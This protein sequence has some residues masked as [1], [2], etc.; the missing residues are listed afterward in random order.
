[1]EYQR[2]SFL[3]W[4]SGR[5]LVPV[6]RP[7]LCGVGVGNVP[8]CGGGGLC[9]AHCWVLRQQGR[10]SWFRLRVLVLGCFWFPVRAGHVL[11]VPA[12]VVGVW[13]V[14]VGVVV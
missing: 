2:I 6:R 7:C 12:G 14:R 11:A 10:G 3:A 9:L 5:V 4:P 13:G 1:M 8:G